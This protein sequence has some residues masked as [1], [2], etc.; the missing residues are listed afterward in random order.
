MSLPALLPR[1]WLITSWCSCCAHHGIVDQM[2]DS[3]SLAWSVCTQKR[4]GGPRT[5]ASVPRVVS[6]QTVPE[7]ARFAQTRRGG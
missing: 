7:V 4:V 5:R 2:I 6:A 1:S 3:P